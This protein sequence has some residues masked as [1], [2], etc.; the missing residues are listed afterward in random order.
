MLCCRDYA[1]RV[2]ASY[3]HQIQPY[4]YGGNISL[5]IE[6][7]VFEHFS[8]LTQTEIKASTKPCPLHAA[9]HSLFP[10]D[11]KQDAANTTAHRKRLI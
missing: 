8:E 2:V 7:I 6:V 4:Y 11:R 5:S 3:A 1:E 9:F 10:D